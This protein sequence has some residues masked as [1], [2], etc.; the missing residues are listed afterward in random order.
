MKDDDLRDGDEANAAFEFGEDWFSG[1]IPTL[2]KHLTR[3]VGRDEVCILEIG[4]WEGRSATWMLQ[5][6]LTG[7]NCV[8]HC[9]DSWETDDDGIAEGRFDRNLAKVLRKAQSSVIKHKGRS[10][11]V[12][13]M[14]RNTSIDLVYVDGSH[15]AGDVLTDMVLSWP[16][17]RAGGLMV[18]DDYLLEKGM[19]YHDGFDRYPISPVPKGPRVAI[20]AFLACF[21][22]QYTLLHKNWQIIIEKEQHSV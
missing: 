3:L 14:F 8:L 4:S 21:E 10:L 9:I 22:G 17:I 1:N 6:L 7:K 13:R 5:A 2:N 11:D 16:L 19:E 18:C 15:L 12:L 20:D